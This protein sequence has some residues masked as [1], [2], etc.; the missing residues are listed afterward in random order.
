[1]RE[2][3][4]HYIKKWEKVYSNGIPEE[5]PL[6]LNQLNKVPSYKKIALCI[7]NNDIKDIAIPKKSLW[8]SKLKRIELKERGMLKNEQLRL[9]D[10]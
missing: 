6:R 9:F 3:I 10:D 5:A 8:Y 4:N 7:L 2:E 1:M